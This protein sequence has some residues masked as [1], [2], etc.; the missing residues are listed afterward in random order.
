MKPKFDLTKEQ[1]DE[2][3][4]LIQTYFEKE[5]DED[6]GNLASMLILDFFTEELAPMFYNLGVE[7]SHTYMA[8]RIE[9]LFSIQK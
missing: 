9:D 8:E 2:M 4:G 7:D 5:R 3:V 1:K 6:I